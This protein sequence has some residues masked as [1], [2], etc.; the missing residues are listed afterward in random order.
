VVPRLERWVRS[1][2]LDAS[3]RSLVVPA[4]G[5]ATDPKMSERVLALALDPALRANE[6]LP[7]LSGQLKQIETREA[8]WAWL[9]SSFDAVIAKLPATHRVY[10]THIVR[11]FCTAQRAQEVEAFYTPRVQILKS[12]ARSVQSAVQSIRVCAAIAAAHEDESRAF[13][14]G[15]IGAGSSKPGSGTR[16]PRAAT[17]H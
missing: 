12:G 9:R 6:L 3:I 5:F 7:I 4:L 11:S 15:S 13:F 10:L 2:G 16:P 8:A 17:A 14:A 1:G